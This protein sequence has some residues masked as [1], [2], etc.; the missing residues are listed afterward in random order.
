MDYEDLTDYLGLIIEYEK[1]K[2]ASKL[3]KK[4]KKDLKEKEK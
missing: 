1:E 3:S 2:K 4:V